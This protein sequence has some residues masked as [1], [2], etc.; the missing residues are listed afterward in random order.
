MTTRQA[1]AAE[2]AALPYVLGV[3]GGGSRTQAVVLDAQ[4]HACGFGVSSSANYRAIGIRRAA[5]HL[6]AAAEAA[7]QTAG[8]QLPLRAAWLGVAG[9][10]RL[11]DRERLLP[12]LRSLANVVR[13]TNDAELVLGGLP[14]EVGVA[15]VAGT[16]SIAVG[17]DAHGAATRAGGWGHILGDEGGGYGIGRLALRA[18]VRAAD[19]RGPATTLLELI[20]TQW[21][22]RSADEL[23]D[24]V[25]QDRGKSRVASVAPLV[26]EAAR[27]GDPVARRIVRHAADDLA[28]AA[29]TA[30]A[31]LDFPVGS[32]PLALGGGLLVHVADLRRR[33]LRRLL[34]RRPVAPVEVVADPALCAARASLAAVARGEWASA[35]ETDGAS[36]T[37]GCEARRELG[38]CQARRPD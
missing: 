32:L 29:L 35:W 9:V 28:L 19:G 36:V 2:P 25:Y 10:D 12:H 24:Q 6:R 8:G 14:G 5:G 16:G 38:T 15:L 23:A 33:V 13:L 11:E 3:D 26:L 30:G 31:G 17:R 21:H 37:A 7:V 18:A 4:G 20:L 27:A 22:L 34:S 1:H